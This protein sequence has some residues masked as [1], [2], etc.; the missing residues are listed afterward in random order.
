LIDGIHCPNSV[1]ACVSGN[2]YASIMTSSNFR[3]IPLPTERAE[4]ARRAV[5]Q[6]ATDHRFVIADSR[7]GYPCRHCLRWAQPGQR[8]ILFPYAAISSGRPYSESGPIFVHAESCERY[9]EVDKYPVEFREGRVMR[10]YDSQQN[11]IA[12][13]VVN[14][15]EPEAMIEK[16]LKKPETAFVHVRSASHGCYTM[17]IER[18]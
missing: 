5:E 4:A 11:M 17:E 3:V 2:G 16:L 8:M 7:A 18:I 12:A 15:S 13:E 9:S 14:A 10:A 1:D 6:G